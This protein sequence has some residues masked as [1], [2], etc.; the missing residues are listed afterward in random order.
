MS[1][2][3]IKQAKPKSFKMGLEERGLSL[4][5]NAITTFDIPFTNNTFQHGLDSEDQAI[6]E[7]YF[8]WKFNEPADRENWMSLTLELKHTI[9]PLDPKNNPRDLLTI[10]VAKTIGYAAENAEQAADPMSDYKFVIY[11][12]SEELEVTASYYG[13]LDEAIIQLAGMKNEKKYILAIAKYILPSAA[14]INQDTSKAYT[15]LREY[16]N[17]DLT[18]GKNEAVDNFLKVTGIDKKLLYVTVDFKE[19]YNKNIIRTNDKQQY[20][21]PMSK[22]VYGKNEEA[23][24]KY[25]MNVKNQDELGTGTS[26][27]E[28]YSI[29]YQLKNH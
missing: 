14:G 16:I 23:V 5:E 17:G 6:V 3:L 19:A 15:K 11:N 24:I 12:E 26:K 8:G 20:Y 2:I 29:R 25:L 4:F 22:S 9:N 7:K 18:K 21:N 28:P 1:G 13:K 10:S 27:D